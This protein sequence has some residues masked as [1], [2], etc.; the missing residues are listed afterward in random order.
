MNLVCVGFKF[1]S[2]G[3][4]SVDNVSEVT[5]LHDP[6][7]RGGRPQPPAL[8]TVYDG[9]EGM[10]TISSVSQHVHRRPNEP[11]RRGYMGDRARARSMENLD[12]IGRRNGRDD[13]PPHRR[14]DE[15][16]GRRG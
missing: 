6:R 13:Y 11:P 10:S 9:D 5:S 14:P 16:R 15:H 1:I 12:D 8:S 4:F 7:S 2:C 3:L